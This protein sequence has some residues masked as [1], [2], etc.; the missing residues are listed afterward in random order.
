MR[1]EKIDIKKEFVN[2]QDGVSYFDWIEK[3]KKSYVSFP[4]LPA[5][6][7][8]S[9]GLKYKTYN[10]VEFVDDNYNTRIVGVEQEKLFQDI[11]NISNDALIDIKSKRYNDGLKYGH[12][13]GLVI[14]CNDSVRHI[15]N[16]NWFRR[17]FKLF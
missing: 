4:F 7:P 2:I 16:L 10:I 9:E 17:L 14:G 11:L 13:S 5:V 3:P 12:R 6:L 1:V 15:K 8:E